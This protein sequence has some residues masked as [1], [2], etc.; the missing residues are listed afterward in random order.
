ME[1]HIIN[2][3]IINGFELNR[4]MYFFFYCEPLVPSKDNFFFLLDHDCFELSRIHMKYIFKSYPEIHLCKTREIP[5][6]GIRA[7]T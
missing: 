6:S 1:I 7:K 4:C 2:F 5:I 3:F